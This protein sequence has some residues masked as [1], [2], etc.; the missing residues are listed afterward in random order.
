MSTHKC[1]SVK[2]GCHANIVYLDSSGGFPCYKRDET[3]TLRRCRGSQFSPN[4]PTPLLPF[5]HT[6][7]PNRMI[8]YACLACRVLCTP[9]E[10]RTKSVS[11]PEK[12]MSHLCGALHGREMWCASGIFLKDTVIREG[13]C[14]IWCCQRE[15]SGL[16][17]R[18]A[19][20]K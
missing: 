8:W 11:N 1:F 5:P 3:K 16:R 2:M 15:S 12:K 13:A 14:R 7:S 18:K 4:L 19:S 17:E 6:Y 20:A 9:G 10:Q